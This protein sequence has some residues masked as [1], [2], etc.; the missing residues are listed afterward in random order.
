MA[1]FLERVAIVGAGI[2]GL[3]AARALADEGHAVQVFDKSRGV[4]GRMATRRRFPDDFDHGA[5]YFTAKEPRFAEQ[6]AAWKAAGVVEAWDAR[7]VRLGSEEHE[8]PDT[9][10]RYVGTPRMTSAPKALAEGLDVALSARVLEIA[11]D[12]D[13]RCSLGTEDGRRFDGFRHVVVATPAPQA[14]PL[15]DAAPSL[16]AQAAAIPMLPC[17]AAMVRFERPVPVHFDAAFVADDRLAWAARNRS[18]PG[19]PDGE[20]WVLHSTPGFSQAELET[21]PGDLAGPLLDALASHAG[22]RLPPVR[23]T[24]VH[25][26]LLAR[27]SRFVG[28]PYLY[29]EAS[30]IA[31][32]GDWLLGDR[33]EAA[34][35]S[36]AELARALLA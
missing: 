8:K 29:D 3:T 18:K 19:R 12:A 36:G 34:H 28:K 35:Q 25:R 14:V 27:A 31:V 1:E 23:S 30:R 22:V 2:A 21:P 20:C 33:V 9:K 10:E 32:C 24:D 11:R 6:V 7:I 5:Q 13:A 26:W 15:L 4:G 16:Q 17:H